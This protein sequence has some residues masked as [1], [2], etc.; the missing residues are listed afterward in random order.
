MPVITFPDG[1]TKTYDQPV[2]AKKVAQDIS[3]SLAKRSVG[4]RMDGRLCDLSTVIDNDCKLLLIEGPSS[5]NKANPDALF[6]LRHSAAH[7]MAEAIQDIWPGAQLVFG[8]PT[9]E[10]FFY[11]I[12][13]P[14]ERFLQGL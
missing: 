3:H 10:G 5:A 12:H 6:L 14:E 13:F 7:V 2:I 8:P 11:D 4:C 1:S 9:D